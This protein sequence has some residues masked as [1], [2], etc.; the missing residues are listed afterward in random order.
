MEL[1]VDDLKRSIC[2]L[3]EV[4]AD[5]NGVQRIVTPIEYPGTSDRIV[6]RVRPQPDGSYRVDENGEA[7]MYANMADGDTESEVVKRWIDD[8]SEGG[9]VTI[10]DDETLVVNGRDTRLIAPSIF[11]VAEAAQHL[12]ALATTRADRH[13]SDLKERLT[14]AILDIA[15][16]LGLK[17]H[18]NVQ[19]PISGGLL[20]DHVIDTP[21]PLIVIAA[22]GATRLLE[23]E[24]IHMQYR[25]QKTPGFVLAVVESQKAVGKKQFERA[26]YYT[27][28]TVIFDDNNLKGLIATSL[29]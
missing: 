10:D 29:N 19:L 26:N 22:T 3:F 23:A 6:V 28:K 5:E 14:R 16:D 18:E 1:L 15:A 13:S 9:P 27:G 24:V 21:T 25:M 4:H 8:L 2:S 20:A 12:Y 7:A 11:R 17:H